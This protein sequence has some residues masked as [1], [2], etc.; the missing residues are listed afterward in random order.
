MSRSFASRLPLSRAGLDRDGLSRA[1]GVDALRAEPHARTVV[2][3]DQRM[4]L[5]GER[6]ALLAPDEVPDAGLV[7]YLG[8][9]TEA[10]PDAPLG[11]PVLA[12]V[13]D[14]AA[15]AIL[16][17]APEREW[18]ELR[19]IG[20]TLSERDA[21]IFTEALGLANWHAVAE[22][23]PSTGR[24]TEIGLS[25]WIRV[26]P[27]TKKEFYPRTDAAIIVGIT[28]E[29]DR[30]LLGSNALWP[31][32]RFSVLA[33]FVEPGES[34]EQAVRRE[35]FEESGIVV[36]EPVYLGSQPWPFPASLMLGFTARVAPGASSEPR[37]DGEE[38]LELRWFERDELTQAAASG[39]IKLP[40]R[41]SIARAIIE[42]W[43]GG[44]LGADTW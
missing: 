42:Q 27:E 31:G 10:A 29:H 8:R 26:D 23:A 28:D 18:G 7:L 17:S 35:V 6:I 20:A 11:A 38:I 44:D 43:H 14:D 37:P 30:M 5:D 9:T 16:E 4:L 2:L 41:S 33:G 36:D 25:G 34:L 24:R 22:Y 15:A 21:G 19:R 40:G 3:H 32:G 1:A 12:A 39:A 13:V